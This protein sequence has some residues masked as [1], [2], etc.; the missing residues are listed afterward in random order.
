MEKKLSRKQQAFIDT[1]IV[2][3]NATQAAIRAG[4]SPRNAG[5][6]A[7]E[8]LAKPDIKAA[9]EKMIAIRAEKTGVTA[10][11]VV[12]EAACIAFANAATCV[13]TD[14]RAK[15]IHDMPEA[16]QRAIAAI[17][18][19]LDV[20]GR[21][22]STDIRFHSKSDAL[23]KLMRHLGMYREARPLDDPTDKIAMLLRAVQGT[24][25]RPGEQ[26]LL[27]E[28]KVVEHIRDDSETTR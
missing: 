7:C 5:V 17:R 26:T 1:Y 19:R 15:K 28:P 10:A 23:D 25:L 18:V 2:D 22:K 12:E 14:G 27:P 13:D 20:K 8:N 3:L 6:I 11:R 16:T 21:V 9:I 24:T 4:Y